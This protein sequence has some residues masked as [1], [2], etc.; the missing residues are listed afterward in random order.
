MPRNRARQGKESLYNWPVRY[1]GSL[2]DEHGQYT[3]SGP[4]NL[5][6]YN[7]RPAADNVWSPPLTRVRRESFTRYPY[8]SFDH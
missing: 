5:G 6:R 3:A 1:H 8:P 7:L 4:D 2:T